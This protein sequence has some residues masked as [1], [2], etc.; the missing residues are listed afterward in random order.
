MGLNEAKLALGF[1]YINYDGKA[2]FIEGIKNVLKVDDC[3]LA[4]QLKKGVLYVFGESLKISDLSGG[5]VLVEG[6]IH[7]VCDSVGREKSTSGNGDK[8]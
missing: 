2:V 5:S 6:I 4:F 1:N 7:A 8:K 3:E